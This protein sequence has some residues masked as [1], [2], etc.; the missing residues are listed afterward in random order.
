MSHSMWKI[1]K[2]QGP[3]F[4]NKSDNLKFFMS[5]ATAVFVIQIQY[6]HRYLTHI[7]SYFWRKNVDNWHIDVHENTKDPANPVISQHIRTS[8]DI[9]CEKWPW[10]EHTADSMLHFL[11][12]GFTHYGKVTLRTRFVGSVWVCSTLIFILF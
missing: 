10:P 12:M 7:M 2:K 11:G 1:F 5:F 3:C 6:I 8:I 9:K 4:N